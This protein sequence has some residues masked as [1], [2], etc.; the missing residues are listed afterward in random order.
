MMQKISLATCCFVLMFFAGSVLAFLTPV[1]QVPDEPNHFARAYQISEAHFTSPAREDDNGNK[2]LTADVPDVFFQKKY[3]NDLANNYGR[4]SFEDI[5]TFVHEPLNND[6][7]S[8]RI[9]RNTGRYA[10]LVYFPQA[11]GGF[12]ARYFGGS[13]GVIF[14]AMRF[15][16]VLFSSM[17]MTLAITL[18]PEKKFLI[19][20]LALMPM[21]MAE[22]ASVAADA[23]VCSGCILVS[24]YILS[25][26]RKNDVLTSQQKITLIC[27]AVAVGL[28]KQVYGTIMLLYFLVPFE[29][30]R[31]R[32]RY[33]LFGI[34]LLAVCLFSSLAWTYFASVEDTAL[35]LSTKANFREQIQYFSGNIFHCLS[36]FIK[37]NIKQARGYFHSFIATLAWLNLPFPKW[38][39]YLYALMLIIAGV[40]GSLALKIRDRLII[41]L[42]I[43]STLIAMDVFEYLTWT[44]PGAQYVE[45]IQGRYFIPVAL[46]AFTIISFRPFL[47]HENELALSVG[48]FSVFMTLV[49]TFMH[50]YR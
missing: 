27:A 25:L 10:P 28:L 22:C 31:P 21:T 1:F 15:G 40:N 34:M 7:R 2:N 16:A 49:K 8:T 37:S 41:L 13:A 19:L 42:G 17:C 35:P 43:M 47:K 26:T 29:R 32:K 3:V 6:V 36:M 38:F 45:G 5:K 44:P 46:M 4:Y 30:M 18:L 23:V 14:Y 33:F 12:L 39:K 24:A 20:L 50:F 48:S 11:L 9:I